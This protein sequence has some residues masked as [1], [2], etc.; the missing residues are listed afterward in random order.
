MSGLRGQQEEGVRCQGGRRRCQVSGVRCQREKRCRVSGVGC[1]GGRTRFQVSVNTC[2]RSEV[3]RQRSVIRQSAIG[4]RKS[5]IPYL[6]SRIPLRGPFTCSLEPISL[7]SCH[8][9]RAYRRL[10]V[11]LERVAAGARAMVDCFVGLGGILRR[12]ADYEREPEVVG[13]SRGC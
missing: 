6:A 13:T 2:Q 4:N 9:P 5:R 3:R 8:S 7:S 12:G 10:T 11:L 1:Q